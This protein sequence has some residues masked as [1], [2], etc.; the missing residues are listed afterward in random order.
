MVSWH[1]SWKYYFFSM[2]EKPN[3]TKQM[4]HSQ[5]ISVESSSHKWTWEVCSV[6]SI[7]FPVDVFNLVKVNR[8]LILCQHML[9]QQPQCEWPKPVKTGITEPFL[10]VGN[11]PRKAGHLWVFNH[12]KNSTQEYGHSQAQIHKY[13]VKTAIKI[14]SHYIHKR[15]IC[16]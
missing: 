1:I 8:V 10:S 7:Y 15:K 12:K 11:P 13:W 3:K 9:C 5:M 6:I 16:P 14:I 2:T 4:R